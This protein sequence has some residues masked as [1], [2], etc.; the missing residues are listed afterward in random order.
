MHRA[1]ILT[2]AGPPLAMAI[3]L[4][5]CAPEP[6]A[7]PVA[8]ASFIPPNRIMVDASAGLHVREAL[9]LDDRRQKYLADEIEEVAGDRPPWRPGVG[10]AAYGGPRSGFDTGISIGLPLTNPF[11][12]PAPRY[13]SRTTF[14][15]ADLPRYRQ[16]WAAWRIRLEFGDNPA[17]QRALEIDAPPPN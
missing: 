5:G 9:L 12:R 2:A 13:S 4:V 7:P 17:E 16:H 3:L 8:A 14:E 10:V 15:I 1:M 11:R 6:P